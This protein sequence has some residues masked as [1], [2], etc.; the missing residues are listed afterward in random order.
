MVKHHVDFAICIIGKAGGKTIFD[1]AILSV[2]EN[3]ILRI[4]CAFRTAEK[5]EMELRARQ[6]HVLA[7]NGMNNV[8]LKELLETVAQVTGHLNNFGAKSGKREMFLAESGPMVLESAEVEYR[9]VLE[10]L[11]EKQFGRQVL[12]C[13]GLHKY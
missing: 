13:S 1:S 3:H 2:E 12:T 5:R 11:A 4:F 8:A 6:E 7:R 9:R 10:V